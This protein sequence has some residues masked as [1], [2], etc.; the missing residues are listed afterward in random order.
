MHYI[1][2][3]MGFVPRAGAHVTGTGSTPAFGPASIAKIDLLE[4]WGG[5]GLEI[6][7]FPPI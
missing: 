4:R 2:T 3:R 5:L 7:P 1:S 6:H